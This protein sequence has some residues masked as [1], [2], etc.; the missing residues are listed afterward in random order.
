M[1]SMEPLPLA[2]AAAHIPEQTFDDIIP[3]QLPPVGS[4]QAAALYDMADPT[5]YDRELVDYAHGVARRRLTNCYDAEEAAQ[6]ALLKA[7]QAAKIGVYNP[8]IYLGV[9]V[10]NNAKD[11]YRRQREVLTPELDGP[12]AAYS[13]Y[14]ATSG[15]LFDD[16]MAGNHLDKVLGAIGQMSEQRRQII[17]MTAVGYSIAE[18]SSEVGASADAVRSCLYRIRGDL[19]K[20]L[21]EEES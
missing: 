2:E 10:S 18:I 1:L 19:H 3:D 11:I 13:Q 21:C 5:T 17:G 7:W 16:V 4:E 14:G 15:D 9:I 20:M 12:T 8:K 6:E